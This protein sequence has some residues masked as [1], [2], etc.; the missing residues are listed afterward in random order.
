MLHKLVTFAGLTLFVSVLW[1]AGAH[2]YT[3]RTNTVI[4]VGKTEV[5]ES[6]LYA[7]GSSIT[8]AGT[9][10]GDVFCVGQN[11]DISGTVEGDVF[12][13]GQTVHVSGKITGG[14]RVAGQ[15]IELSGAN[16]GGSLTVLGQSMVLD[17]AT[18]VARDAGILAQNAQ[19]DGVI[20][21]DLQ[22]LAQNN[23]I[24][25]TVGRTAD[26]AGANIVL[27][28]SAQLGGNLVY[29]SN[30]SAQIDTGAIVRG[31]TEHKAPLVSPR[32][33]RKHEFTTQVARSLY[34]F[35]A[36]LAIGVALW[37]LAPRWFDV[38]AEIITTRPWASV[39]TGLVGLIAVPIIF[40]ALCITIIGVPL[41]F[42]IGALWIVT[43][44]TSLVF[45][46][47]ALGGW[48]VTKAKWQ[49]GRW[50]PFTRLGTGLLVLAVLSLV[51]FIGG[52]VT[53]VALLWGAG[54]VVAAKITHYKKTTAA[55]G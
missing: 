14:L 55:R 9:V 22:V 3:M 19:V 50:L 32:K 49:P 10:K 16:V 46:G 27:K 41:A 48:I 20:K 39:G 37:L 11:V 8:I 29:H 6:T 2:A 47:N 25:A 43:L 30:N 18:V 51:P 7:R 21:R 31:S 38:T 33:A 4:S 15:S 13:G 1:M 26:L 42:I 17:Q 53:F 34:W 36:L 35:L 5:I 24:G 52:L 44:M 54:A 12:C 28:S 45:T 23:S 40:I